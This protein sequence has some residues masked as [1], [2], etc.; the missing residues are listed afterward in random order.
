M[1]NNINRDYKYLYIISVQIFLPNEYTI[2]SNLFQ[3]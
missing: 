3:F 1:L 2:I